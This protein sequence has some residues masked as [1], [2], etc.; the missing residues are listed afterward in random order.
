MTRTGMV[1]KAARAMYQKACEPLQ[2]TEDEAWHDANESSR[3]VY[4]QLAF[5]ALSSFTATVRE[6][7]HV[8]VGSCI[9]REE[10]HRSPNHVV[11]S[12]R[13]SI[14]VHRGSECQTCGGRT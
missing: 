12:D 4:V 2:M 9:C 14:V 5:V 11:Y 1:L 13:D 7:G 3:E 8:S 10:L 6:L